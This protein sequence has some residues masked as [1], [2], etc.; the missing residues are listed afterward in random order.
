[1]GSEDDGIFHQ[2]LHKDHLG[3]KVALTDETGNVTAAMRYDVW[4][5][6]QDPRPQFCSE[7]TSCPLSPNRNWIQW[8]NEEAPDWISNSLPEAMLAITPR[9]FT[10]HEHLDELGVIHMNGRIYDPFLAR[11]LQADPFTED[12]STLNRYTYVH[13]SPLVYHDPS[14][15]ISVSSLLRTAASIAISVYTGG[16]ANKTWTLF[17]STIAANN[18]AATIAI[19]GAVSGAVASGTW[20]GAKWGAISGLLS[21]N[22]GQAIGEVDWT[23]GDFAG[24]GMSG[25]QFA[26]KS[27]GHGLA[28]GVVSHMQGGRFGHGFASAGVGAAVSPYAYGGEGGNHFSRGM[29]VA[30]AGGGASSLSGGKFANG[31][32]SAAMAYA[33]NSMSSAGSGSSGRSNSE[34]SIGFNF[35]TEGLE[36]FQLAVDEFGIEEM[37]KEILPAGE[38]VI[39]VR[40]DASINEM[41]YRGSAILV[42]PDFVSNRPLNIVA[43]SIGHELIHVDDYMRGRLNFYDEASRRRSEHRAY[44]W[45]ST[46][47]SH[48]R[49][50]IPYRNRLMDRIRE[51]ASP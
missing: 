40:I 11:F 20:E 42:N 22:V 26:A 38:H 13:N 2:Y 4:G 30:I 17:G 24:S 31:A 5:Q 41:S 46:T 28:G 36:R 29:L 43:S 51:H 49:L 48:F 32:V 3:S 35:E 50:P 45:Q 14:G 6:R 34:T 44:S 21:Y 23:S 7:P 15:Y 12:S 9:G 1:M 19:G 39:D 25:A 27:V 8:A 33:F 37:F 47:A 10:G 16:L 18:A